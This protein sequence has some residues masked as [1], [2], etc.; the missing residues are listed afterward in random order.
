M[1]AL[2][3]GAAILPEQSGKVDVAVVA[4]KIGETRHIFMERDFVDSMFE[5][6]DI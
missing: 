3:L 6:C 1:P 2:F 4:Y 5:S